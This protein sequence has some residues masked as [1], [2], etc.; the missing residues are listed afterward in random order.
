MNDT[1]GVAASLEAEAVVK[2]YWTRIWL[3]RDLEWLGEVIADPVVRH[4]GESSE[5]LSLDDLRTRLAA[6]FE[7]L[8]VC[9]VNIGA[10]ACADDCVWVRLTVR[11]VSL[12][13]AAPLTLAWMAQYRLAKGRIA[14]IWSLQRPGAEWSH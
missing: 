14:E 2:R 6:T 5:T 13:T 9:D 12:A 4:T 8:R 11:G 10:M 7:S 1:E 3:E